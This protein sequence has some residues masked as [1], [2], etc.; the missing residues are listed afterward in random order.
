METRMHASQVHCQLTSFSGRFLVT[1]ALCCCLGLQGVASAATYYLNA[2]SG[3]DTNPGTGSAPWKTMAKI[4]SSSVAGDTI[5]LAG[6]DD[7]LSSAAWPADR[8]CF[9]TEVYQYGIRWT[10]DAEKR[11]GRF[12][13]GDYWV[14]GPVVVRSVTPAPST[15]SGSLL[16]GSVVNPSANTQGYDA[17]AYVYQNQCAQFPLTLN[18]NSSLVSTISWGATE[19]QTPDVCE[20]QQ[21][22][23]FSM[24]RTAAVLTVLGTVP[25]SDAF[26]PPYF[27]T[28]KPIYR[29]SSL[30]YSKL[31]NLLPPEYTTNPR[32]DFDDMGSRPY[33]GGAPAYPTVADRFKRVIERPWIMHVDGWEARQ[34]HPTDNQ[35]NYYRETYGVMERVA[36]LLCYD[37]DKIYQQPGV[38]RK[39][40]LPTV[41]L[42]IDAYYTF[43]TVWGER[44]KQIWPILFAGVLL[45]DSA[46]QNTVAT[47]KSV[48]FTYSD[49][50][51]RSEGQSTI[52]SNSVPANQFY[53]GYTTG[54]RVSV[55]SGGE[56]EHLSP[57]D[58]NFA[59]GAHPG[60]THGEW[61]RPQYDKG[62]ACCAGAK[63]EAYRMI[64][65]HGLPGL[66]VALRVF[67]MEALWKHPA[68]FDYVQRFMGGEHG[69]GGS[70][71]VDMAWGTYGNYVPQLAAAND[72]F[73]VQ[74]DATN[75]SLAVL[76]NDSAGSGGAI[77]IQSVTQPANGTVTIVNGGSS[78]SYTPKSGFVGTDTFRYTIANG[79]SQTATATV[80]ITV[81][82]GNTGPVLGSIG[83]QSVTVGSLLSFTL[84]A[85]DPDGS[86]LTYSAS[87]LPSG[88]TLTGQT[89]AW[90]P[91]STQVGTYTVTFT[92]SD[93]TLTDSKTAT[94]SVVAASSPGPVLATIGNK[95]VY[96]NQTLTFTLSATDAS[97]AAITYGAINLPSG[98]TLNGP[99]FRWTPSSLQEGVYTVQFLASDS[100]GQ[101]S[102]LITITVLKGAADQPPVLADIGSKSVTVGSLLSFTLSATDPGSGSLTYSANSLPSGA[103]L[104]GQTF[105][106]TPASTQAGTYTVTFTV[107]DGTLTDS[108]TATISVVAASSPGPVLATIGNKAVYQNQTLTFTLSATDASGATITY[109]A[110]N[111]PSGATL[112][113]P[114]FRWT[115]SS[116]QEG[117]YTTQFLASDSQGQD[118]E[119][120]TITVLKGAADQPPV[121]ADIGSKSVTVGS[122]LSFALSATDPDS[123]S[124]TYSANSLPSGAT[125]T[126]QTFA[127]T[128]ASAQAGT[129]TVTFTVSDGI[130]T[131]SKTATISVVAASSP[132]PVLATIGNKAVYQN[133]TLT[134]TLSATDAS[135]A[136]VT[137]GVINLPSGATLN[138]PAFRWTPSSLQE[139]VY[140]VQFLASDS[141]GQDSELITITVLKGAADQPP[142]LADI[143]SKTV[144]VGSLL[145]F[146]LSATDPDSGSLTY[147]ANSL[148][149]GAT[150]AGQTF[151]WT[152]ASTQAGTYTVTFT[153]SDGTLTSSKTATITVTKPNVVP[154]LAAIG[155]KSINENQALTFTISA[156]DA[157]GNPITY[158]ATG[159][160]SGA[161]LTGPTFSWTPSYSQAGSYSVTFTASDGPAQDSETAT[162]TVVNVD[163]PPVLAG[164]D[165]KSV[166]AGSPLSFTLSATDPDGDSLT[167]SVGTLPSGASLT[168]QT[169]AWTPTSSQAGSFTVTFTVSDGTLT[170][171]KTATI[172]V[173]S[174]KTD[175]I[176]PV[177]ARC[178][179]APDAIQV[180]LNNLIT[181][182]LTDE[183]TGVDA[184][185]VVIRVNGSII[186]QG[187]TD[188]GTSPSGP[189]NRSG[190]KNDYR[191]IYQPNTM[192]DFDQTVALSVNAAD[193]AGNVMS[194]Y[195]CSF[196]T[197]MRAFSKNAVVSTIGGAA[198][199]RAVT[200]CDPAGNIWVAWQAGPVN[201]RDI[202][203]A[204]RMAGSG[205]FRTPVRLTSDTRDQCNPDLAINAA[206]AVY[207]VW[208]DNRS[209]NWDLYA[210]V[211]SDGA[212]FSRN[213][214][215]TSSNRNET[216][217][218]VAVDRQSPSRVYVAWQDDRSG[219]QDIYVASSTNAFGTSTVSQVTNNAAEQ[220]DPDIVVDGGNVAYVFWTDKR[221]GQADIYAAASASSGA[222]A[223]WANVP[224]VLSTGDQT[225]PAV[226]AGPDSALY[227]LWVDN[228]AGNNDI[229][230]AALNGLPSS[231]VTGVD[232][233][234]DTSGAD[235]TAPT[236]VCGANQK[237]FACWTD[238]RHANTSGTDTDLY[239]AELR[240]ATAGVNVFVG[241]DRTDVNQND[242]A[243]GVDRYG[244][245]YVVWTDSRN[246]TTEV[247]YAATTLIDPNP[248]DAKVVAASVGAII[249][250][251][252]AAIRGPDDVSLVVPAK[253]CQ[254]DLRMA[255]SRIL[256]PQISAVALLGSWDFSPSGVDFDQPVTVTIPYT[257]S[258]TSRKVLPYWYDSVT[259][260]LSQQG[261]TDVQNL[262]ISSRLSALRFRTTHFTPFYLV[263]AASQSTT[264]TGS[265]GGGCAI[266]TN[267]NGSPGQ[268]L[269][270]YL[271]IAA[272][273]AILRCK[274]RRNRAL[275]QSME[276]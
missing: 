210:A 23:Q 77:L 142:V 199:S 59:T 242:P 224:V 159:L 218:A 104:T 123:S 195:R 157:D 20:V 115:P 94:I 191:F 113:G 179:P 4:Q 143:G 239:V 105:A 158:S 202:Y 233:I 163:R 270:P 238:A 84:S 46:L 144:N 256:N 274:D 175:Q 17:R 205:A 145:S 241:D 243:L 208:Q 29:E 54:Y 166:N 223:A 275:L 75:V 37:L 245:P 153:V 146:A 118:S 188:V 18:G 276:G 189:C 60:A 134:F 151:A 106:W 162:I 63:M 19:V 255:I 235:Q 101:D 10:L 141:H 267:G 76:S 244:Q 69:T 257:V 1:A 125:L 209:G 177:V 248:L 155:N 261:I 206:G 99:A 107:S 215:V 164:I 61:D 25:P 264:P 112:N 3:S 200:A 79:Q 36:V 152:P 24:L 70:P 56:Y 44:E 128:P 138:G 212:T 57:G 38:R 207:V 52:A 160:P 21:D 192:F 180:P 14:L 203:V 9:S 100:H 92:V 130:L 252:P 8:I 150:L 65:S 102:E 110:V 185:S 171:S 89:F 262:Y 265:G 183:G 51:Y 249:G 193:L 135:G 86:S 45:N 268:M 7:T 156:T 108:K 230:Y 273:M 266:S 16:N 263:E 66:Y 240:S 226:A 41:Q 119:L 269:V 117:V 55:G 48:P 5:H 173:A 253:A 87:A 259:G 225:Q 132:G 190:T 258:T 85:T 260:A 184:N 82:A 187:N 272:I 129:Y 154:V 34:S 251:D 194:E 221:N 33:R 80:T 204:K 217:P 271:A 28:A 73:T 211:S 50:Y 109:G 67:H 169:F 116:L 93:G 49:I 127:W 42:G 90:T 83:D 81:A 13:N 121:L 220:T 148:P 237:V 236:I 231:P 136:T 47:M 227:L 40:V 12:I 131:N 137:Y 78:L 219:N 114:A 53:H 35:P 31:P 182:H 139:G 250:A 15:A 96:Q 126:G 2:T 26:R 181:L 201:A 32:Y 30:D 149:S 64:E 39:L 140:T 198:D 234:D 124:L 27:G 172:A 88:A 165:G 103:T 98:A 11:V 228:G 74:K 120:I 62:L 91:T 170:D 97:G 247:Y 213:I 246:T 216:N 43:Q 168:G 71:F 6:W 22:L 254:A 174:V 95:A 214:R 161:T 58:F 232:I 167:Y 222:T 72:Q 111:L 178:A 196:T 197:E 68:F 229:Y 122:L 176:A 147:S 186:Y 133:Q